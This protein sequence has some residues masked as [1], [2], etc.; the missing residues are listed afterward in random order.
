MCR[1]FITTVMFH[2]KQRKS[3]SKL[4]SGSTSIVQTETHSLVETEHNNKVQRQQQQSYS[5]MLCFTEEISTST[6]PRLQQ[7]HINN[8]L[9]EE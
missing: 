7:K 8:K 4:L 5:R 9:I 3:M 2:K 1:V 6:R